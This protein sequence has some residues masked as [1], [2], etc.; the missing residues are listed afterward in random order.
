MSLWNTLFKAKQKE[1]CCGV[2][3]EEV[4]VVESAK[5]EQASC[6]DSRKTWPKK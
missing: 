1:S 4:K 3:I 2:K 5:G 6:C